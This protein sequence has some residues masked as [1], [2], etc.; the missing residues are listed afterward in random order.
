MAASQQDALQVQREIEELQDE[1]GF[2]RVM[3]RSIDDSVQDREN[4]EREVKQE[5]ATIEKRLKMLKRGTGTT[6]SKSSNPPSVAS[7]QASC[8]KETPSKK[9][10]ASSSAGQHVEGMDGSLNPEPWRAQGAIDSTASTPN[11]ADSLAELLTP[12]KMDLPSRKRTHSTHGLTPYAYGDNKSR[13]TSPS[14]YG[15]GASS[16]YGYPMNSDGFYDLTMFVETSLFLQVLM[17]SLRS[18][19]SS[20]S[21]MFCL[22]SKADRIYIRD[23]EFPPLDDFFEQ[24][25]AAEARMEQER[26]DAEFAR[27]LQQHSST[28][29]MTQLNT[30]GPSAFDR[31]SGVRPQASS[32]SSMNPPMSS[33]RTTQDRL[34]AIPSSSYLT[35]VG[36][37][38]TLPSGWNNRTLSQASGSR[39]VKSEPSM[40][41]GFKTDPGIKPESGFGSF[42][43]QGT[44]ST[45]S[46]GSLPRV[47]S[48]QKY[49]MPGGFRD[50]SSTASDSEIEIIPAS[51]F[52]DNGRHPSSSGPLRA[53]PGASSASQTAGEA[54]LRRIK[55]DAHNNSL[56]RAMYGK[57]Q[58]PAWTNTPVETDGFLIQAPGSGMGDMGMTNSASGQYVYPSGTLSGMPAMNHASPFANGGVY[59]HQVG[60]NDLP[61][62]EPGMGFNVNNAGPSYND[63][64]N[65]EPLQISDD[66]DAPSP[67]EFTEQMANQADYIM[68]DPRKNSDEIKQLLENIRP[69]QDLPAEDREGTPEGLKYPLHTINYEPILM[70]IQYEHQK[71]ALTWLKSMEQGNNK[72][73]ILAD[74]MGLGKTISA[75]ALIL[76]RQS[77]DPLRKTTLIVGP[78]ALLRQWEREIRQKVNR[79]HRLSVCIAHGQAKKLPWDDLRN[80]DVVLTS[81]GTLG[82]EAKRLEVYL[83]KERKAGNHDVDQTPMKKLFPILGPKSLFYRVILDEAQ[84]IKN[85]NSRAARAA[86]SVKSTY[87]LC[88]TGTP[89]MN[90]VQ[91]LYSLIHFLRIKPYNSWQ[92]F[93]AE[94]GMLSKGSQRGNAANAMQKLQTVLKAILLRR[95]KQSKIDGNPIVNLPPKTTETSH[96]IF[97]EDELA[98]YKALE[99]KTRVQ[100]NKYMRANTIGK[101]YSNILVLLLRLRQACCHPHLITDFEEAPPSVADLTATG[102]IELAESLQPDCPICYDGVPN[103][104][105]IIPCGHTSCAECL[106]SISDRAQQDHIARGDE[107]QPRARCPNCRGELLSNKVIDY[108]SFKK[109]HDPQPGDDVEAA[110]EDPDSSDDNST[111]SEA[112]SE[113]DADSDGD[114]RDFIVPD[115]IEDTDEEDENGIEGD[116][117][118]EAEVEPKPKP[119]KSKKSAKRSAKGRKKDK[120]GKGKEKEKKKHLSLAMLKSEGSKSAEGKRRYMKYLRKNWQPSAKIDKCVELLEQFQEEGAK[121][122][123]FS[124]FVSL[125]DLLQV[126]ID[127]KKWGMERYDGSMKGDARNDAIVRFTDNPNCKI[128]LIS[129]KAGNAGLNLVAASRVIILDPFWNPF[130]EFQAVDRA[131]RIGQQNPVQVHRIL[132]EQTVEDRI[133]ELQERKKTFVDAALDEG[134]NKSLGRLDYRQLAFLF[135]VGH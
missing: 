24:Q 66:S 53:A 129:L 56:H 113:D 99:S 38:R 98:F 17:R 95:T 117:E 73:G 52:R 112:E 123:V 8:S 28:S 104:S 83:E 30:S 97:N 42:Q 134:A 27:Q 58:P 86:C 54:A 32:S 29:G 4:A 34:N 10:P 21:S 103:P 11:S 60:Q 132:I 49:S 39:S 121:T 124:Q 55:Q 93:S 92:K 23:D 106:A 127:Q 57:Y 130:I 62:T 61:K 59:T 120:K 76:S 1:L 94:F 67:F 50:D 85:K 78:V 96:V 109:V 71:L 125:L 77:N 65:F 74:D 70:R 131:Y 101:N 31:I 114:L 126:P 90:A 79:T 135:G 25:Q 41:P 15:S 110:D 81:Y 133:I 9:T 43:T 3:L 107:G 37:N 36:S 33:A 128:M 16:G 122:I 91:E 88:L 12:S 84:S 75:L 26:A 89:M 47:K 35:P 22:T 105:I 108:Q 100:F 111:E 44:F 69:D 119:N 19:S 5:I 80:Y 115:D 48:E 2:Q 14:P 82:A 20:L 87:R 102:M 51:A 40:T 72:G 7:S 46:S 64:S 68:N 63:F 116:N 6:A 18:P 118:A 45:P 13:R